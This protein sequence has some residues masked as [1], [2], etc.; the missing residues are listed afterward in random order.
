MRHILVAL[1]IALW[2]GGPA[3]AEGAGVQ[4]PPKP[5]VRPAAAAKP[6]GDNEADRKI[7]EV[8]K[9]KRVTFD[10]VETPIGDAMNFIQQ[11][12]GVNVVVDPGLD[13]GRAL[14]LRVNDM[15]MGQALQW[16]AKLADAKMEVRDGAVV[17]QRAGEDEQ[18]F[19]PKP[20]FDKGVPKHELERLRRLGLAPASLGKAVI[21][22]GDGTSVELN[23]TEDDLPPETRRALLMLL[24]KQLVKELGKHDPKA[25]AEFQEQAALRARKTGE[26]R[27]RQLAEELHER[28]RDK[29]HKLPKPPKPEAPAEENKGQF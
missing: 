11:L 28:L 22:L 13:K 6:A 3:F 29:L 14:T 19:A 25:A 9:T 1:A 24:H 5:G 26:E 15:P 23:L 2:I 20:K 4:K 7:K 12:L 17:I 21:P 27:A 18:E 16:I 10:F 8:L